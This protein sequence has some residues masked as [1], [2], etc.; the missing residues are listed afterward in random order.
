[1]DS[2]IAASAPQH[3]RIY[4]QVEHTSAPFAEAGDLL[5]L[6]IGTSYQGAGI[7]AVRS[8]NTGWSGLRRIRRTDDGLQV[9]D[10]GT[11]RAMP[12]D[13]PIE[14]VGHVLRVLH[15]LPADAFVQA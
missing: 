13:S 1:M 15:S 8:R 5:E 10:L 12:P 3:Q 11:W 7:Y 4:A 6:S 2:A 14:L 9:D